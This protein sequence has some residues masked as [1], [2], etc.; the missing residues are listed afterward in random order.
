MNN[1]IISCKNCKEKSDN[2]KGKFGLKKMPKILCILI[3]NKK[4]YKVSLKLE[5][6]LNIEK[7]VNSETIKEYNL[8]SAVIKTSENDTYNTLIKNMNDNNWYLNLENNSVPFDT[9]TEKQVGKPFLLIY[10]AK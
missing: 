2:P 8:V 7:Y 6:K 10:K 1:I 5:E 4:D 3:E 9:K